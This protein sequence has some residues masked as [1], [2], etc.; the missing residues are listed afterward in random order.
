MVWYVK[1]TL[2]RMCSFDLNATIPKNLR[3]VRS[4]NLEEFHK[5][6]CCCEHERHQLFRGFE[7]VC[8]RFL[9]LLLLPSLGW[10]TEGVKTSVSF[11][12]SPHICQCLQCLHHA[13][14]SSPCWAQAAQGD[15]ALLKRIF[16]NRLNPSAL[17]YYI[18]LCSSTLL[19]S[20]VMF[21]VLV[22]RAL[23]GYSYSTGS[24]SA[25]MEFSLILNF[26]IKRNIT[27]KRMNNSEK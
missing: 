23:L 3:F 4:E 25:A 11:A 7:G 17:C 12:K 14:Y 1:L 18:H 2:K 27:N 19:P 20:L 22:A 6:R 24:S 9:L 13:C 5:G 26:C 21:S 10:G 8:A 15:N 16:P